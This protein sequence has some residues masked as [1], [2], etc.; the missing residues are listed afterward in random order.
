MALNVSTK[1]MATLITIYLM[2][3]F[4]MPNIYPQQAEGFTQVFDTVEKTQIKTGNQ[5]TAPPNLGGSLG[6]ISVIK[7]FLLQSIQVFVLL[8]TLPAFILVLPMPIYAKIP[9]L[10]ISLMTY[11]VIISNMNDVLKTVGS[12]LPTT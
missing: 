3:A 6:K 1:T 4:F 11:L 2:L 8:T 5:N 7:D 10:V 9:L 12:I